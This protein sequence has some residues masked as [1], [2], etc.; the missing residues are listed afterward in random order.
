MC[1]FNPIMS[2]IWANY[3]YKKI[4]ILGKAPNYLVTTGP[5]QR[6]NDLPGKLFGTTNADEVYKIID[7]FSTTISDIKTN[8]VG[9]KNLVDPK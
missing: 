2:N 3:Y 5:V 6:I 4:Q 8:L 1:N 7:D 9:I